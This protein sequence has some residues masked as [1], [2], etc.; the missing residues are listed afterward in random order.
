L[1][2]ITCDGPLCKEI[3][4]GL[5]VDKWPVCGNGGHHLNGHKKKIP[6]KIVDITDNLLLDEP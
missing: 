3:L 2:L 1:K 4:P 6:G 5:V